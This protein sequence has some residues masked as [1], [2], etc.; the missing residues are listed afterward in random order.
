MIQ[1]S[2]EQQAGAAWKII[3]RL[4]LIR[5]PLEDFEF[6]KKYSFRYWFYLVEDS[7]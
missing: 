5:K 7:K 1:S 4:P 3:C 2:D 6:D